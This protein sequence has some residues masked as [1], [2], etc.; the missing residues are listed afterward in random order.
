MENLQ[1]FNYWPRNFLLTHALLVSVTWA[2]YFTPPSRSW[3]TCLTQAAP[4]ES[5]DDQS[6]FLHYYDVDTTISTMMNNTMMNTNFS[7]HICL[8]LPRLLQ[9]TAWAPQTCLISTYIKTGLKTGL[10]TYLFS[11]A[12][13]AVSWLLGALIAAWLCYGASY[14]LSMLLL[15]L[16]LYVTHLHKT[17]LASHFFTFGVW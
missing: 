14:K 6:V 12:Y 17:S 5:S 8:L 15:L 16:L 7:L 11:K 2:S 4:A 1:P 9:L 10:K 13:S 3:S